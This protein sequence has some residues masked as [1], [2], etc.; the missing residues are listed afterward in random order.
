MGEK[1]RGKWVQKIQMRG[2]KKTR[3]GYNKAGVRGRQEGRKRQVKSR[4]KD[5][6]GT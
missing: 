3:R 1:K 6:R 2:S 5:R 4:R